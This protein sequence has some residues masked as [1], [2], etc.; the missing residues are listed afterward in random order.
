M[1]LDSSENKLK[2]TSALYTTLSWVVTLL[3]PVVLVMTTVRA[4]LTPVYVQ[5]EYNTPGFPPDPYGFTKE[6]RLIWSQ[7][8]RLYLL[9]D[10]DISYLRDL[11]FPKGQTAP[12]ESCRFMDDCSRLYNDRELQHMVDVK[13]VVQA[14]LRVWYA[15]LGALAL[16]GFW[17][18]R[19]GWKVEF[20]LGV[21]RG[22]WLTVGLLAAIILFVVAAFGVIFVVFHNV[23]FDAG[24]WTFYFSDT[25]IRL[26]PERFWR[27]TF[28]VV[29]SIAGG[30]GLALGYFLREKKT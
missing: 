29:G 23:F 2:K 25:L 24:T 11:R 1:V 14:A 13:N 27:D 7:I 30:A 9:N 20:R 12:P 26:F 21:R 8:A 17:A 16:L 4:M 28:L 19:G 22:G 3:M 10:E 6:D 15:S 5:I 18:W